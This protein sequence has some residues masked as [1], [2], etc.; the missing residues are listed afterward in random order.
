MSKLKNRVFSEALTDAG[1]D[2]PLPESRLG[3]TIMQSAVDIDDVV[4]RA[5]LSVCVKRSTY[6]G[7]SYEDGV[8]AMYRWLIGD[9]P[10]KP[11]ED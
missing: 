3:R 7:L 2:P 9:H 1:I 4:G 10:D 8:L 6:P 5:E 11:M